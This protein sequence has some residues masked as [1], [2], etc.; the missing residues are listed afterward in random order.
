MGFCISAEKALSYQYAVVGCVAKSV[1][2]WA[3]LN[4][5]KFKCHGLI[6]RLFLC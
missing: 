4:G 5:Y 3:Q 1:M 2:L 6:L